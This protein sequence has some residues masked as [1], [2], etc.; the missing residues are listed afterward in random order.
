MCKAEVGGTIESNK[1][2]NVPKTQFSGTVITTKDQDDI[3]RFL[4][5]Q[6]SS[7]YLVDYVAQAFVRKQKDY[8]LIKQLIE[9]RREMIPVI[10]KIETEE[11]V[12]DIDQIAQTYDCLMVARGDLGVNTSF[13]KV[14]EY[15]EK[16]IQAARKHSKAVIVATQMLEAMFYLH[17]HEPLRP[18]VTD[19]A[20][21]VEKADGI[22]TSVETVRS[23]NPGEI[24]TTMATIAHTVEQGRCMIEAQYPEGLDEYDKRYYSIAR[25][26]CELAESRSSPAIVVS[27]FSGKGARALAY[28]RPRQP[29]I[30]ITTQRKAALELLLYSNVYPVLIERHEFRNTEDYIEMVAKILKYLGLEEHGKEIVAVFG[31]QTGERKGA[32]GPTN[33]I[34]LFTR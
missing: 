26:A 29:I 8:D 4:C 18:E 31:M 7:G 15:Q 19:I 3:N 34:R 27:T 28:F 21:A 24:V 5:L 30:A 32:R 6:D 16:I 9:A 11:A 23:E 2:I 25:A 1:G 12:R 33:T 20:L 22:M 13:D 10:A 14:P 17:R